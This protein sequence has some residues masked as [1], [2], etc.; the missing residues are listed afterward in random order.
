MSEKNECND[1]NLTVSSLTSSL[2]CLFIVKSISIINV[3]A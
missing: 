1:L 2:R 3:L